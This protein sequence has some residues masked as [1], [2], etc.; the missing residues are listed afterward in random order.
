MHARIGLFVFVA[1]GLVVF[2][3]PRATWGRD[4]FVDNVGGDDRLPGDGP[5]AFGA[6]GPC[7]T[8]ARA[9]RAAEKGDRIIL[10]NTGQPYFESITFHSGRHSGQPGRPF[11]LEGNGATLA[12]T[13]LIPSERWEPFTERIF[14][15]APELKSFQQLYLD[16]VPLIQRQT[17]DG[18]PLPDLQPLE[19]CLFRG[20]IYFRP[21]DT[22]LPSEYALEYAVHPVGIT[23]YEVRHVVVSNLI[24]QGFHLDGVN[25][26]DNAF[27]ITLSGLNC[28]GNGRSGISVGGASRVKI[29]ACLA[30]NNGVAQVR[31]EGFSQ[32]VIANS[33]LIGNT[34]P[35]LVQEGGDVVIQNPPPADPTPASEAAP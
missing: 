2:T 35:P 31:T 1:L 18:G 22:L 16:G 8:I 15:F 12:G 34:A 23:L 28:R 25:A 17:T 9:L 30:G 7:R 20:A 6:S 19:W 10:A 24:V 29:D 26:H 21:E 3:A 32:T 27:E 4:I 33:D 5:R 13:A 11:V 14:R